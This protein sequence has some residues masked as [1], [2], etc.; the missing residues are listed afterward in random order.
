VNICDVLSGRFISNFDACHE[1]LFTYKTLL[2]TAYKP[3]DHK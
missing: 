2:K 3:M 1:N